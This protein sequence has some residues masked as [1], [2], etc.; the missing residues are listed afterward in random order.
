MD[1]PDVWLDS[2]IEAL[3]DSI[4]SHPAR[5][6]K[7]PRYSGVVCPRC[8]REMRSET[9]LKRPFWRETGAKICSTCIE[10]ERK[11]DVLENQRSEHIAHLR[12]V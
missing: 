9:Y 5:G 11:M 1:N 4:R 8:L 3:E 7:V 2:D 6:F 12:D 10:W